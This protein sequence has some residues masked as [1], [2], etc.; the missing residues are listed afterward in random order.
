MKVTALVSLLAIGASV[1]IWVILSKASDDAERQQQA[2]AVVDPVFPGLGDIYRS[3]DFDRAKVEMISC[4]GNALVDQNPKREFWMQ[5]L[6]SGATLSL[7]VSPGTGAFS[8]SM[9]T[10]TT[11]PTGPKSTHVELRNKNATPDEIQGAWLLIVWC[12][13]L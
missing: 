2:G 8:W 6:P 4:V 5:D 10:K 13:N 9:T 12:G 11:K 1:A 7:A 3:G